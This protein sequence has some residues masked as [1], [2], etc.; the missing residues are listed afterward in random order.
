M[1]NYNYEWKT[2]NDI[3]SNLDTKVVF[4]E[5]D[6][7]VVMLREIFRRFESTD[8]LKDVENAQVVWLRIK[9]AFNE[10][11]SSYD[12]NAFDSVLQ[13][14]DSVSRRE[15]SSSKCWEL[16]GGDEFGEYSIIAAMIGILHHGEGLETGTMLFCS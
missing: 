9:N 11:T 13:S 12:E 6:N 8:V 2:I 7:E 10:E 5:W 3:I 14:T 4:K 1:K 16:F 15:V